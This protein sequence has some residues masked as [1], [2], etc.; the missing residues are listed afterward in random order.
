MNYCVVPLSSLFRLLGLSWSQVVHRF[1]ALN[2][3]D[4]VR[5]VLTLRRLEAN[6][7]HNITKQNNSSATDSQY[8]SWTQLLTPAPN[9]DVVSNVSN[10]CCQQTG[11]RWRWPVGQTTWGSCKVGV[12]MV[13]YVVSWWPVYRARRYIVSVSDYVS[14]DTVSGKLQ[15]SGYKNFPPPRSL[16][17]P[18]VNFNQLQYLLYGSWTNRMC[19]T[20]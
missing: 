8:F 4:F 3:S 19:I 12:F 20:F 17:L 13:G 6:S 2:Y 5:Y 11:P 14:S 10:F 1:I 16:C 7:K 18:P 9:Q 15:Q